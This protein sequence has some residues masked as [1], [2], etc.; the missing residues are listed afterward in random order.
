MATSWVYRQSIKNRR[1]RSRRM[2][3]GLFFVFMIWGLSEA[4]IP[5]KWMTLAPRLTPYLLVI[6]RILLLWK[7]RRVVVVTSLDDRAM[8]EYGAEF[9]QTTPA[10]QSDLLQH[11]R[12]GMFPINSYP[13]EYEDAQERESYLRAYNVLRVFLPSI[14]VL[15]L[16]GWYLLPDGSV[17][18]AWTNGP[19][20]LTWVVLSVL[21]LPQLIRMWTEPDDPVEPKLVIAARKEA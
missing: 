18:A 8:A 9:D 2:E 17:R 11:Y 20:I 6:S 5:F 21:A 16:L 19:A 1:R 12:I 14:A 13:D 7:Q 10:Q 15:Y 4:G 3:V